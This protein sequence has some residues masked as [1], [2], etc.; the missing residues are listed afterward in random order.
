M[1][2]AEGKLLVA[3][4]DSNDVHILDPQNLKSLKTIKVGEGPFKIVLRERMK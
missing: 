1:A 3:G 2:I 4:Y